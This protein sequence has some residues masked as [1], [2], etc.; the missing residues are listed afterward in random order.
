MSDSHSQLTDAVQAGELLSVLVPVYNVAAYLRESLDSLCNQTY[1][2]LEIICVDD[3][4]TDDSGTIL[5]EYASKDHRI[6]VFHQKNA[7]Q[8]TARQFAMSR[9]QGEYVTFLDPD[10][11]LDLDCY[12]KAL[13]CM[14]PDVDLVCYGVNAFYDKGARQ[15]KE[16]ML[17]LEKYLAHP[18]CGKEAAT[19]ELLVRVAGVVW[20]KIYRLSLIRKYGITFPANVRIHED[21]TF[22]GMYAAVVRKVY[23]LDEK[24]YHYRQRSTST[25][26]AVKVNM[27]D[28]GD[29]PAYMDPLLTFY[30]KY[31]FFERMLPQ[32]EK[33]CRSL[34]GR[35]GGEVK[36]ANRLLAT[37]ERRRWVRR[38]KL[39]EYCTENEVLQRNASPHPIDLV[40]HYVDSNIDR[41]M[42]TLRSEMPRPNVDRKVASTQ[43][44]C[45]LCR[46]IPLLS[47]IRS[48]N[49]KTGRA[50]VGVKLFGFL[51][52]IKGAGYA[53]CMHWKLF[54]VLPICRTERS[55]P[56]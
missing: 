8:G 51:P 1:T 19:P 54:N 28:V 39:Q 6:K 38:W 2:N 29:F 30:Q 20:N 55:S 56:S 36:Q 43:W 45:A 5:Q 18:K 13:S 44:C 47:I 32:I 35:M 15:D 53:N 46:W 41:A 9:A 7:G 10:D 40:Q 49:P 50:K 26:A 24:L 23:F 25:M 33:Q 17:G 42:R 14:I 16:F 12:R 37:L 48:F 31:G 21:E 3:G 52:L 22:W 34:E 11:Y 4:S 27:Y